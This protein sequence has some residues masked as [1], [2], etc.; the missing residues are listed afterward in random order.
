MWIQTLTLNKQIS[1]LSGLVA[2]AITEVSEGPA[3]DRE[4]SEQSVL[5][6]LTCAAKLETDGG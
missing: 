3:Q 6:A 5:I 4:P 2:A 1:F